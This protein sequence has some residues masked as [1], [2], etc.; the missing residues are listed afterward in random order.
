VRNWGRG[1]CFAYKHRRGKELVVEGKGGRGGGCVA[2]WK[3]WQ[4]R[5]GG[6]KRAA[7]HGRGGQE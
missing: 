4:G 6:E 2:S 5:F 7:K 3:K 1:D